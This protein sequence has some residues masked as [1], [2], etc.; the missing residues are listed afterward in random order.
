MSTGTPEAH[1][2]NVP[3]WTHKFLQN[4]GYIIVIH[5]D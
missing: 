5:C 2:V 4:S 3:A 1:A